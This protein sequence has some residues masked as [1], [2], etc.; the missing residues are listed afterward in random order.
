M[1]LFFCHVVFFF[2]N[3]QV[4]AGV[5]KQWL[6]QEKAW[7]GRSG[8]ARREW[9]QDYYHVVLGLLVERVEVVQRAMVSMCNCA[10]VRRCVYIVHC[11][12]YI[13]HVLAQPSHVHCSFSTIALLCSMFVAF[14]VFHVGL[15]TFDFTTVACTLLFLDCLFVVF[16]VRRLC[17]V[18]LWTLDFGLFD[19]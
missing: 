3:V 17:R 1:P 10:V 2:N 4:F 6:E 14:A 19:V 5:P 12:L 7:K 16:H 9:C 18:P 8:S 15:L 13:V 11:T